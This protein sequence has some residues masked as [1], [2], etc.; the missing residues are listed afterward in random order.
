[1]EYPTFRKHYCTRAFCKTKNIIDF[2]EKLGNRIKLALNLVRGLTEDEIKTLEIEG[3]KQAN[4]TIDSQK[5]I[6]KKFVESEQQLNEDNEE[7]KYKLSDTERRLVE[8]SKANTHNLVLLQRRNDEIKEIKKKLK[9]IYDTLDMCENGNC[10]DCKYEDCD[11]CTS[12]NHND[13]LQLIKQA[14]KEGNNGN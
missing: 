3:I 12:L 4:K 14:T 1:M 6:I 9:T 10:S 7:L 13:V 5:G 11:D 2:Y 8:L